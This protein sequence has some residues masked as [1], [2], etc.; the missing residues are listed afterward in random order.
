MKRPRPKRS[1][2]LPRPLE[3]PG[4][5]DLATLADVR[6]LLGHL[7]EVTRARDTWQHVEAELKKAEATGDTMQVSIVLRM[8]LQ[9]EKVEYR[10][11]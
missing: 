9:L 7:S 11:K 10:L 5:M 3:I 1:Q 2:P 8:V 4:V 6:A